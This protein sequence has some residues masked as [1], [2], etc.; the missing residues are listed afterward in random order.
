MS[1]GTHRHGVLIDAYSIE[2]TPLQPP[3]PEDVTIITFRNDIH[4]LALSK[5]EYERLDRFMASW[6]KHDDFISIGPGSSP[7]K[8]RIKVVP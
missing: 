4:K 3:F 7:D 2:V 5:E 6:D 1:D 8:L